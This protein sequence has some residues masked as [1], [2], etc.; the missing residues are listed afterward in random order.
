MAKTSFFLA[1]RKLETFKQLSRLL[2]K[3]KWENKHFRFF[4]H[5]D[6]K[7]ISRNIEGFSTHPVK[8]NG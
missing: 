1:Y 3:T 8:H 2:K 4:S 5:W 7:F 6:V